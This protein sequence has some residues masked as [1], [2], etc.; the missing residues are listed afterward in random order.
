ML[1]DLLQDLARQD[2]DRSCAVANFG[3]LRPRNVDQDPGCGVNNVEELSHGELRDGKRR[4][5][6]RAVR[7]FITVAPSLV[8]VCRP[9]SSTIRRSPPYGPSVDLIVAC[10]ARHALMLVMICPLPWE[11]S[12]PIRAASVSV[13]LCT[14]AMVVAGARDPCP[15][16][17][18]MVVVGAHRGCA[19]LLSGR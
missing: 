5:S 16:V 18:V 13:C 14:W 10:T 11:E 4:G 3:V 12:V 7:T 1:L 17:V 19:N 2:D 6:H 9:F 15:V 8:I